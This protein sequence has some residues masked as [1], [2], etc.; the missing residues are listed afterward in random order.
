MDKSFKISE[1]EK[2]SGEILQNLDDNLDKRE[3]LIKKLNETYNCQEEIVS[4]IIELFNPIYIKYKEKNLLFTD[5]E[6][7]L[8][9]NLGPIIYIEKNIYPNQIYYLDIATN[10]IRVANIINENIKEIENDFVRKK[11]LIN[12]IGIK[13]IIEPLVVNANLI[14]SNI[15]ELEE[16]L[17]DEE[18]NNIDIID[19]L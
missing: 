14:N 15:I 18:L 13:A 11:T 6:Q 4:N 10:S 7:K 17:N 5:K 1:I 9:L 16:L 12:R 3:D 8:T 2:M 19:K